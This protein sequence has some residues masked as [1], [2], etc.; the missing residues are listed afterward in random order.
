[1]TAW[2]RSYLAVIPSF[3]E[4]LV[5]VTVMEKFYLPS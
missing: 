4:I 1:M 3:D 5:P 2:F